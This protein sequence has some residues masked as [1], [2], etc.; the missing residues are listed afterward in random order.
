M[1]SKPEKKR[2]RAARPART[3]TGDPWLFTP[4]PLT[5]SPGVKHAMLHDHG[6]R[7]QGFIELTRRIRDRLVSLAR[8]GRTHVCVPIQGSGTFAV[9]AMVGTLLP[10]KGRLLNLVNGAY[11]RRITRICEVLGRSAAVLEISEDQPID[12]GAV[13]HALAANPDITHVAL[14]H[15]ETTSGIMNPVAEIAAVAARRRRPLL[16]DAMSTLGAMPIDAGGWPVDAV[17]ASSNKCLEGVPGASFCIVRRS[18]LAA[19]AGNAHSLS[20]DLHAQWQG[21]EGNGQWRF[22]PPVHCLLALDRAVAELDREGGVR[23]RGRRYRENCRILVNGMRKMGFQTY[24]RDAV[25]GPI[26]VTFH[27]PAGTGFDFGRF[28]DGLRRRGYVIYP[29]KVTKTDTF[30]IGCIGRIGPAQMRGLL[31]AVRALIQQG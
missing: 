15:C 12:P 18:V 25:Q 29:G 17:A 14:V 9:E 19:C 20:L 2:G 3:P 22:T 5:T 8:G 4:G 7:D 24:L 10:Q 13:D 16:L 6:S 1:R 11:G 21:F 28:Y 26:I 31:A 23:A 30:R 27:A